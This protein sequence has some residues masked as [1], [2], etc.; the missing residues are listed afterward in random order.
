MRTMGCATG[1]S[2]G[3]TLVGQ[4]AEGMVDS[5]AIVHGLLMVL[6]FYMVMPVGVGLL[7]LG[8]W[9]RWHG[10]NQGIAVVL[11]IAG[12]V[13]AMQTSTYYN[14]VSQRRSRKKH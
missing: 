11:A 6:C 5:F 3:A 2:D 9:V 10:V 8:K 13:A 7:R 1:A 12:F 4:P 14:R